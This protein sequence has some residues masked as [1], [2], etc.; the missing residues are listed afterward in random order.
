M[1][2][3]AAVAAVPPTHI[4][5]AGSTGDI[6]SPFRADSQW[7]VGS[8]HTPDATSPGRRV[9]A[10]LLPAHS[11]VDIA[12]ALH[13]A[14]FD[15]VRMDDLG[16]LLDAWR[17]V[18]PD[19]AVIDDDHIAPELRLLE[20]LRG[21]L[22]AAAIPTVMVGAHAARRIDALRRGADDFVLR[23]FDGEDLVL[24]VHG[25]VRRARELRSMS[26]LTGLPGN[27]AIDAVLASLVQDA[28]AEYAVLYVDVDNFKAYNDAHGFAV[29]DRVLRSTTCVLG[30]ALAANPAANKFLG[31]LGGDDF[32]V[33]TDSA[34]A[35][36]LCRDI[37]CRF[38]SA[39]ASVPRHA[40]RVG[41]LGRLRGKRRLAPLSLSIGVATTDHRRLA[42]VWE[43]SAVA[44]EMKHVAKG[45]PGSCF[46]VDRRSGWSRMDGS[47]HTA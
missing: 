2:R 7:A 27:A 4:G 37:L 8:R 41:P 36:Q 6:G 21:D 25:L 26:P 5:E 24:R 33:V 44:T 10:A 19:V 43:V 23:P 11:D 39:M 3:R 42:T 18:V 32:V 17:D 16:P 22:R 29:G 38:E 20:R 31:H 46:A 47:H 35:E 34:G 30:A 9:V 28:D 15:V 40:A 45:R 14:G 12:R 13:D 1:R